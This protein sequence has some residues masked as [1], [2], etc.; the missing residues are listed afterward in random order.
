MIVEF[1]KGT[2]AF[3]D[4][5]TFLVDDDVKLDGYSFCL[6][7]NGYVMFSS[8]KDGLNTKYL[9][10]WLMGFPEGSDI[11]H[12]NNDKLDNRRCNLRLCSKQ[13]NQFNT[14]KRSDNTSGYKGVSFHTQNNNY[15]AKISING[16]SKHIGCFTTAQEAHEAYCEKAKE[17]HG[18]FFNSGRKVA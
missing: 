6:D 3:R 1:G 12:K 8:C 9:H 17:L 5:K 13:Q 16:K 15:V 2:Q 18:E 4:G 11:D 10:R 14:K 7:T